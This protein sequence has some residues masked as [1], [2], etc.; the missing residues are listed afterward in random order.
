[1]LAL[2]TAVHGQD[3]STALIMIA[4]VAAAV[5]WRGLLK[6]GIAFVIILFAVLMITGLHAVYQEFSLLVP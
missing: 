4:A 1:M 6:I 3:P 5:F 2:A